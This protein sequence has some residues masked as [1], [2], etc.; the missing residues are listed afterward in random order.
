MTSGGEHSVWNP[1]ASEELL[2]TIVDCAPV[3]FALFDRHLRYVRVNVQLAQINGIEAAEHIGRRPMELLPGIPAEAVTAAFRRVLDTEASFSAV[4][5]SGVTPAD[6][7]VEHHWLSSWYPV[8]EDGE[9]VGVG[10]FLSDITGRVRAERGITLL[11]DVGEA[12]DATLGVDE[13]LARLADL[14]VPVLA[15][16]CTIDAVDGAGGTRLVACA[17]ADADGAGLLRDLRE[18]GVL[19]AAVPVAFGR[20]AP[21]GAA[22]LIDLPPAAL[23]R[24]AL[25]SGD[26]EGLRALAP[27]S[28]VVAPIMARG[29]RLGTL[30]LGMGSSGRR[31]DDGHVSLARQLA[32]RAGLALDN[33]RLYEDQRRI[34]RTLQRSLL[35]PDLPR[36]P[37]LDVA[38]RFSPMG[39]GNEVGGDFYDMFAAGESWIALIGDVCGKGAEAA[40]LTSLARHGLRT[41]A[42]DDPTPSRVLAEL[43]DVI[44]RERGLEPRFSTVAYARLAPVGGG[45]GVTVAS[46]GHPLPLVV[47]SDGRV[48][49]LG[50]PGTLLGPFPEVRVHDR[51]EALR[52]GDA[53]VLYTDG[54]TEARRAGELFGDARLRD[55]LSAH[56]GAG[57]DELAGAIEG[58]V[59]GF[60]GG[61]LADDLAVLVVRVTDLALR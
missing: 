23:E 25:A 14:L 32:R 20:A 35:P 13:R 58:A 7:G 56:A 2:E 31:H 12:L 9:V 50:R 44:V 19:D 15:D 55:L 40:A 16:F 26:P 45:V 57:A 34:A 61:P 60:H 30:A 41:L 33:A 4:E 38:A 8:R 36:P 43:N 18:R 48:E 21:R 51:S 17:H 52:P 59:V 46:A 6:P 47:R 3:G 27:R 29:R 37:G 54:V 42:R 39:G 5:I 1:R 53:I 24:A 49:P 28:I 22:E 10:M 11:S